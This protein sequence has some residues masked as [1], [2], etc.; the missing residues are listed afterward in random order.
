MTDIS[1]GRAK[2]LK[3]LE[4]SEVSPTSITTNSLLRGRIA[5]KWPYSST[6]Q[7]LTFLLVDEDIR[8][9]ASGGQVRV[10]LSGEAAAIVDQIESGEEVAIALP[11]TVSVTVDEIAE[12]RCKWHIAFP[13]GCIL[14]VPQFLSK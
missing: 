2:D 3:K 6:E 13:D 11:D 1:P 9:R 8:K 14:Q 4:I 10:T 5:I 7:K 12:P